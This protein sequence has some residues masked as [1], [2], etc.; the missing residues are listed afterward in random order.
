MSDTNNH[1]KS[2]SDNNNDRKS[3]KRKF[4]QQYQGQNKVLLQLFI[5]LFNNK[6]NDNFDDN[7]KA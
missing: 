7:N 3:R 6:I 2:V 1:N 4:K 5:I